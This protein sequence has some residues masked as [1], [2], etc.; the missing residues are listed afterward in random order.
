MARVV[1]IGNQDFEKIR[2]NH[3]FY[4]DKTAFIREWWES[5]DEVTLITRPRRFGKTLNMS[6]LE[7]FFSVN[8]KDRGDLFQGLEIWEE[9]SSMEDYKYRKLQGTYPVIF[10]SFADIKEI[11]F[12]GACQKICK[13]IQ[14]MYN[15]FDFLLEGN[16][17]N[18]YEKRDFREIAADRENG[19]I[20][21]SIKLLSDYLCRYYGKKVIILLDEY[22]TPMQEAYVNGYWEEMA[23]FMRSLFNSTF[24][25]NP[26]LERAVM[27]GITRVSKESIFSDL[28][29]LRVI[30]TTSDSYADC[31]GFA[32]EEVFAAL[33]EYGLSEQK[34]Q[35][36]KWYD[37]FTFGSR[38]DIYNPWSIIY[39]LSERKVGAYW[40][41]SSSNRLVETLIREGRPNIKKAF[42]DLLNGGTL[43]IEMDE[44]IVYNQ[45]FTKKNAVW[46][47]LLA[48]GYL[49]VVGRIL[50][51]RTGHTHYELAL[52][53]KEVHVM[54]EDMVQDWF[55]GNDD[56]NDFIRA[57]LTDDLKSMNVYMNRV[58]EEMFS[59]FDT[60]KKPSEKRPE[61]FYHG[62]VLGL[63]V[64]L[65]DRYVIT[66]NRES[67]FGRYDVMLE[68]RMGGNDG[69][70]NNTIKNDGIII[71]FKVQEEDEKE[72]SDTV[73]SA[74]KQIDEKNYQANL[75][76]K[77]I[78]EERIKR[79][80]FAFCGKKVLIGGSAG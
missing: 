60:G 56:Y 25:T 8:Y 5:E 20:S 34:Q 68:P 23:A 71:E 30:T 50:L 45:L 13:I 40:A 6:M 78:P 3:I 11:T 14:I 9:K 66:S 80:G 79:Y 29:N 57:L 72:L 52:T 27:T 64:E 38:T 1:G 22:D 31:F 47:L 43:Q 48:S 36:K 58:T 37:G 67:G 15:K 44:Q 70:K 65:E 33:D 77:G 62:F 21:L 73:Q 2:T 55:S 76:A 28:N 35:V 16:V 4:I 75:V 10:L 61:C 41:N 7:K 17:L 19:M 46:S 32:E 69:I 51:E 59:S 12:Q 26:C 53:N 54:F 49:K 42:E 74:L 24:K 18:E 39:F 63:M